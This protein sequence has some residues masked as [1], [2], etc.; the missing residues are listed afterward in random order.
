MTFE[1]KQLTCLNCQRDFRFTAGEQEFF[2]VKQLVNVPKICPDCRIA[3]KAER[4][5]R[6]APTIHDV[7]CEECG[8]PTRVALN[9]LVKVRFTVQAAFIPGSQ[10]PNQKATHRP[11]EWLR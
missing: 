6:T 5:G 1:D 2:E 4:E 7:I 9:Q 10:K 11:P 3:H 8:Q